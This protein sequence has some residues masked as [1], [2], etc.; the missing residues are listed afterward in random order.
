MTP[1]TLTTAQAAAMLG[2]SVRTFARSVRRRLHP[3]RYEARGHL[4]YLVSEVEQLV[5]DLAFGKQSEPKRRRKAVGERGGIEQFNRTMRE[6]G[7]PE[8]KSA[9]S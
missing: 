3:V 9:R 1:L 5:Q 7:L 2:I 6:L 4:R 8:V